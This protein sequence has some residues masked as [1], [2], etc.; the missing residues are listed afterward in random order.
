M[1]EFSR[2]N[3]FIQILLTLNCMAKKGFIKMIIYDCSYLIFRIYFTLRNCYADE[4]FN[5]KYFNLDNG[6]R[7]D[8]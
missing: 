4:E 1:T 8:N 3:L 2:I 7:L 6:Y 5:V